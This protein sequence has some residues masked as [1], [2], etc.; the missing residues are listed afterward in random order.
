MTNATLPQVVYV[1]LQKTG[2][3]YLRH[4]FFQHPEIG[5]SRH[6]IFFQTDA[7]DVEA[8]GAD[9]VRADYRARLSG[10][11]AA[12]CRI[13]MYEGLAMGYLLHGLEKWDAG[14]FLSPRDGLA[15][16]HAESA[17][18]AVARRIHAVLP[19]ARILLTVRSQL[20]WLDSN[21]RWYLP[22]LPPGR[23]RFQDFLDTLEGRFALDAGHFDRTAEIYASCFG[24]E[25]VLV[26]PLELLERDEPASL[27]RVCGFL[28]V[29]ALPYPE[30][31]KNRNRGP[32]I[33]FDA[34]PRAAGS[35]AERLRRRLGHLL[36]RALRD[37]P[38]DGVLRPSERA[39]LAAHYSAANARLARRL[40]VDLGALGYP[41]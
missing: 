13:D 19:E 3:T 20:A 40:G 32:E 2:S 8:R 10:E 11:P 37:A 22:L 27:A 9:A 38:R 35:V 7:A 24:S 1:G 29:A 36:P 16:P 23:A 39:L 6:G 34:L 31:R 33:A 30:E 25:R 17:P 21:Y 14:V 4:Y 5:C 41:V 28:G 12:T 26:L 18:D 15:S